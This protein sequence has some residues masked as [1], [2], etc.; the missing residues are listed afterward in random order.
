MGFALLLAVLGLMFGCL[1]FIAKPHKLSFHASL[2][3]GQSAV[4][5][6]AASVT[7]YEPEVYF[8]LPNIVLWLA[9]LVLFMRS[10]GR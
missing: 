7:T 5:L 1:I 4:V 9:Y 2:L 10:C 3:L 8:L 6:L